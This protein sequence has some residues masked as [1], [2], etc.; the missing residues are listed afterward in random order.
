MKWMFI[1][2]RVQV[3]TRDSL[4]DT[5]VY[6]KLTKQVKYTKYLLINNST[7]LPNLQKSTWF[8]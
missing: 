6:A 2:R 5:T 4:S 7:Y 8:T 3:L 1:Y